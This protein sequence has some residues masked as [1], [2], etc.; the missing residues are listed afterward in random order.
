M[1][2]TDETEVRHGGR[3]SNAEL[4]AREEAVAAREA[5]LA[6]K[7]AELA[8]ALTNLEMRETEVMTVSGGRSGSARSGEARSDTVTQ[9][10][11]RRR[12]HAGEQPN[13]FHIP[14]EQI[15]SGTSY[16][17]NNATVFGMS[18]PS[19]DSHMAMQGWRPVDSSRHPHLVA[20]GYKGPIIVKG[21]ILMERP[22]ELTQEALEEDYQNAIGQVRAKEDQLY[23]ARP[24]TPGGQKF[25]IKKEVEKG[26]PVERHYQYEEA[27]PLVR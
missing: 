11:R 13:E 6:A 9:P 1:T 19:Y 27:G 22:I 3:P 24:N 26:T 4:K 17:W 12:Y 15:P 8:A 25:G 20:E 7:E 2:M 23:G 18:N 16:Q 5:E 10:L 14:P 21:Q